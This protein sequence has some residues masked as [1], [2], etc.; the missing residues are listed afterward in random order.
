MQPYLL[1]FIFLPCDDFFLHFSLTRKGIQKDKEERSTRTP[2]ET[3]LSCRQI[4]ARSPG[5]MHSDLREV[6]LL[7]SWVSISFSLLP[8]SASF[9]SFSLPMDVII[10][11]RVLQAIVEAG[12]D[13]FYAN[14]A[15][16]MLLFA[17]ATTC[18]Q[19]K[20]KKT[21]NKEELAFHSLIIRK[22]CLYLPSSSN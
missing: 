21:N 20:T 1:S 11:Y 6:H 14:V 8:V 12:N 17:I 13:T 2:D 3:V 19:P 4:F 5:V 10:R 22:I 15:G 16:L 9:F 7:Y 18:I